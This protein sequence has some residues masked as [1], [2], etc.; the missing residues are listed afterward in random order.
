MKLCNILITFSL[1][2]LVVGTASAVPM[3]FNGHWYDEIRFSGTWEQAN[4]DANSRTHNSLQGHL[5]TV[6]SAEEN[7][8]IYNNIFLQLSADNWSWLG[9]T[10]KG[11]E[12]VWEWVTGEAWSYSAWRSGEPNNVNN[13]DYLHMWYTGTWNDWTASAIAGTYIIEYEASDIPEPATFA[14]MSLGLAGLGYR[15]KCKLTA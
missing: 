4:A 13:E 1:G 11:Q 14:L 5:A 10:D 7:S 12:G 2:L 9:G 3:Q 15:R 8:F 6:T